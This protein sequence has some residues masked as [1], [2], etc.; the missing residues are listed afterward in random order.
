MKLYE[1]FCRIVLF[2]LSGDRQKISPFYQMRYW[3]WETRNSWK[4]LRWKPSSQ[5]SFHGYCISYQWSL[6]QVIPSWSGVTT[7]NDT[8][9]NICVHFLFTIKKRI[10]SLPFSQ[11]RFLHFHPRQRCQK[12]L[13]LQVNSR[14]LF[15]LSLAQ[16][17][18][19]YL[20]KIVLERR[21][22][23]TLDLNVT[24]WMSY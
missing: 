10:W 23:H 11:G 24:W 7:M 21:E 16:L 14:L 5:D 18:S 2:P 13:A 8:H 12:M 17:V 9:F 4:L 22:D 6:Q 3:M 19:K 20:K 1:V 15:E